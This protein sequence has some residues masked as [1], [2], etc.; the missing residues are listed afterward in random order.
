MHITHEFDLAMRRQRGRALINID[1][2]AVKTKQEI[3]DERGSFFQSA[4]QPAPP[5][6]SEFMVQVYVPHKERWKCYGL[7]RGIIQA[8]RYFDIAVAK[9]YSRVRVVDQFD[10]DITHKM[11]D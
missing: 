8:A 7:A 3:E 2:V 6:S 9:G 11:G 4:N 5:R 10:R 1:W